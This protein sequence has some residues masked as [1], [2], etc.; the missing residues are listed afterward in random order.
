MIKKEV[1]LKDA[2]RD[3]LIDELKKRK[4]ISNVFIPNNSEAATVESKS[5]RISVI[6]EA[7]IFVISPNSSSI[8]RAM[9]YS[10][11]GR[12]PE[13]NAKDLLG[14]L[15]FDENGAIVG[16][17][18]KE[19]TTSE[20]GKTYVLS[21][22][23]ENYGFNKTFDNFDDFVKKKKKEIDDQVLRVEVKKEATTAANSDGSSKK[24]SGSIFIRTDGH[25]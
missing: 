3:E 10:G 22:S 18:N 19:K 16:H 6:G 11:A 17:S 9:N 24:L 7:Y 23:G 20:N 14:S 13:V 4:S 25:L 5:S 12:S 21:I 8:D 2:S 15:K 1:L